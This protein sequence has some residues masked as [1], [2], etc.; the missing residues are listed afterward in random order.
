MLVVGSKI[1]V[2]TARL[3]RVRNFFT[4]LCALYS[5]SA[6]FN[7]ELLGKR[8]IFRWGN[9][10]LFWVGEIPGIP[11]KW[12]PDVCGLPCYN[13]GGWLCR[14]LPGFCLD[15][16]EHLKV[17]Y[18]GSAN[19]PYT[20]RIPK[21]N[22]EKP[23]QARLH[24]VVYLSSAFS[25]RTT[26]ACLFSESYIYSPSCLLQTQKVV[27]YAQLHWLLVCFGPLYIEI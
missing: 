12:H 26:N 13:F 21:K 1:E 17:L 25:Y 7:L 2:Y 4:A 10:L 11:P 27:I 5:I 8:N 16:L 15:I 22:L 20:L 19:L 3:G 24:P 9:S 6:H 14:F 23:S 18:H